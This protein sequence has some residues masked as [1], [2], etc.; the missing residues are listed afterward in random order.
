MDAQTPDEQFDA[1]NG[2][3]VRL[4]DGHRGTEVPLIYMKRARMPAG[5]YLIFYRA[6][7]QYPSETPGRSFSNSFKGLSPAKLF[8]PKKSTQISPKKQVPGY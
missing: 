6:A 1:D 3:T 2:E 8:S 5:E 4:V 7:F